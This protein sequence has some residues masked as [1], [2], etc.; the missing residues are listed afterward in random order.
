MTDFPPGFAHHAARLTDAQQQALLGDVRD[1]IATAPLYQPTMPR[2]GRPLSVKMTNCGPLGWV[3]DKDGG[4][5]YQPLHPVTAAPWPP[6]PSS[7]L[8]LWTELSGYSAPPEACLINY[9]ADGAKMGSHVDADEQD[10]SAPVLSV[11]LGDAATFHIGGLK[12]SDTKQRLRLNSGDVVVMGGASR[13]AFHGIDRVFAG[14]S[15]L[16]PEGGRINLTLRRVTTG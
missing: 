4:Y 9:Y 6:I 11:S 7:L 15:S 3:C 12:R 10:F 2:T 16:L 8:A 13:R 1:A 5:R 14:T